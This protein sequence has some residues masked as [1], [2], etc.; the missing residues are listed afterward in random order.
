[1]VYYLY[2]I[3]ILIVYYLYIIVLVYDIND[4]LVV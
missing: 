3:A 4:I 1:M 2:I